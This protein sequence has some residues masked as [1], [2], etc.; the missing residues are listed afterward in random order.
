V[1]F[2]LFEALRA[3]NAEPTLVTANA[4]IPFHLRSLAMSESDHPEE[5]AGGV[6]GKV[7]GKAKSA[8]G[9]LVGNEE[10][11]REG[12]LQQAKVEADA[13][14]ERE[15]AAAEV[16]RQQAELLEQRADAAAERDRLRTELQAEEQADRIREHAAEREMNIQATT[17]RAQETIHARAQAQE[18]AADGLEAEALRQRAEEAAHVAQL[19]R[20]ALAA[21]TTAATIDPEAK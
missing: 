4:G 5:V 13:D 16:R 7:V 3:G 21:E 15:Q 2:A 6:F 11:Q 19:E 20:E 12:N 14:A 18:R 9:S 1:F 17:A 10:L 8:V